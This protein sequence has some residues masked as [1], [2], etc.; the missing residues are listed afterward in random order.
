ME[1]VN[2]SFPSPS[3]TADYVANISPV[4]GGLLSQVLAG[5]TWSNAILTLIL[6]AVVYDQGAHSLMDAQMFSD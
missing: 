5:A 3:A 1:V 6:A 4:A 2:A